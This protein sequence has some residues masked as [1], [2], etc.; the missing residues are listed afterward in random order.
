MPILTRI[1]SFTLP[2]L[3]VSTV[4]ASAA[5]AVVV[6]EFS[7]TYLQVGWSK[8]DVQGTSDDLH[9][10]D[11][12]GSL[13]IFPFL[14]ALA[15]Y[16]EG[17]LEYL[18]S[19]NRDQQFGLGLGT[20]FGL[21]PDLDLVAEAQW[22]FRKVDAPI[23]D[24]N[25]IDLLVGARWKAFDIGPFDV[26]LFA[27]ARYVGVNDLVLGKSEVSGWEAGTRLHFLEHVSIGGTF[28]RLSDQESVAID[29]RASL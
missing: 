28:Q 29:L 19:T 4:A 18:G 16:S 13:T 17:Q 10:V 1:A 22:L 23:D 15:S 2:C 9:S 6:S 20:H 21:L 14:H 11:L 5:P 3:C 12:K 8:Q 7:Y 24:S 27:G 26:E 25:G